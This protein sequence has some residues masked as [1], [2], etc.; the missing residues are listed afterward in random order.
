MESSIIHE[1]RMPSK[2]AVYIYTYSFIQ[3]SAYTTADNN[4]QQYSTLEN[5][6]YR[7]YKSSE[8][9]SLSIKH[10]MCAIINIV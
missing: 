3:Q 8:I 2:C 5:S 10:S 9:S 1:L 4:I 6:I 7:A